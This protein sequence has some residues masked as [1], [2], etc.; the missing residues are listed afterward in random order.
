MIDRIVV[1]C[2]WAAR[3]DL[4]AIQTVA[5]GLERVMSG[6]GGKRLGQAAARSLYRIKKNAFDPKRQFRERVINNKKKVS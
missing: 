4:E 1:S 6:Y 2:V 3:R 5:N